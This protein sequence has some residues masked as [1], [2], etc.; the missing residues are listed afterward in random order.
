M[1]KIQFVISLMLI[2]QVSVFSQTYRN[3]VEMTEG[4]FDG[5]GWSYCDNA[6]NALNVHESGILQAYLDIYK[7]TKDKKYLD[8][9]IIHVKRVQE[10]RDDNITLLPFSEL[11][12]FPAL[13]FDSS[14]AIAQIKSDSIV[15][16][17]SKWSLGIEG[18]PTL[19]FHTDNTSF[20]N[21]DKKAKLGYGINATINYRL[22]KLISLSA[23][24]SYDKLGYKY[25]HLYT[26]S[27]H[28]E[29]FLDIAIFDYSLLS[30]HFHVKLNF[31]KRKFKSYFGL[32]TQVSVLNS[33]DL[34]YVGGGSW[35]EYENGTGILFLSFCYGSAY[36]LNNHLSII[37]EFDGNAAL[38]P[39]VHSGAAYP[40]EKYPNYLKYLKVNFGLN[41]NF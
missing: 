17:E 41:Y 18:A 5:Q 16:S 1:K 32:G 20:F 27:I 36:I 19:T 40:D 2:I 31:G 38:T 26:S 8:K 30:T 28:P 25:S 37:A 33:N 39:I 21:Y 3:M 12:G 22:N 7:I 10:R 34:H 24:L 11:E 13:F 4:A 29:P 9:F 23:G 14:F 15:K 6:G 35:M